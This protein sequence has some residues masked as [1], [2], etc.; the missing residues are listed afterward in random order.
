M[1]KNILLLLAAM[2]TFIG[3]HAAT[4]TVEQIPNVHVADSSQ[5]VSNPDGILQPA[6]VAQMNALLRNIRRSTSAEAVAVV[7]DDIDG[8]DIDT[9]ATELFTKWGLGKADNDNGL[10]ILVA[11]DLRRA[12]IR[13]G[14]GLEG[15]MP[16]IICA[17]ILREKM[18]PRFK[19]GDFDGGMLAATQTVNNIIDNPANRDEILSGE[20][21]ADFRGEEADLGSFFKTV[22]AVSVMITLVLL[23]VLVITLMSNRKR[24]NPEKYRSLNTLKPVYL[25]LTFFGLG[26]PALASVPLLLIMSRLRNMPHKCPRCGTAMKKVDEVLD[27]D[28]LD[29]AQD[30]EERLGSVDYDVWLCPSCGETDIE[31]FEKPNSGFVRCEQCGGLTSRLS[32]VRILRNATTSHT[33]EGVKNYT[34]MHCGHVTG[35]RYTIPMVAAAPI[36]LG[37]GGGHRGGGGGFGGGS[38]GGGFGGGMTGGGGASGGW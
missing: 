17:K 22:F 6:T 15:V 24:T 12:T 33:G 35:L 29:S 2:L 31:P 14:Y 10:L 5:Y 25:A 32:G 9:F 7:V 1:K 4:Y 23:A 19:E 13:T 8:G 37:G 16:D 34:C 27:N 36:I 21:D 26:V 30:T 11:K 18:F 38:F 3:M 28:F 20:K